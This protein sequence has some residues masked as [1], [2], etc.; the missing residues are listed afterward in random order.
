MREGFSQLDQLTS[1]HSSV[2]YNPVRDEVVMAHL[3]STRQATMGDESCASAFGGDVDKCRK[4]FPYFA[5]VFNDPAV[6]RNWNLDTFCDDF[7]VNVLVATDA[8]PVWN[9]PDSWVWTRPSLLANPAMR[10][11]LCGIAA[12]PAAK[13]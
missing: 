4:A 3:Y 5:V 13:R 9:D 7:Q 1:S 2:Q 10:A 11:V 12:F 8:D 6:A